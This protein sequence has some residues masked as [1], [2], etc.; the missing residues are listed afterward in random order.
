VSALSEKAL[1]ISVEYLGPAAKVFL[2]RQTKYHLDGLPFDALEQKHVADLAKWVAI[3]GA[4]VVEPAK[5]K[6]L[7]GKIGVIA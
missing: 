1:A 5:A 3:S 4:L 6:E 7:A 2:E